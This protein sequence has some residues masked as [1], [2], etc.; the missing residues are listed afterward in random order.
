MT[1]GDVAPARLGL[2]GGA[3][4]ALREAADTVAASDERATGGGPLRAPARASS[5]LH[6]LFSPLPLQAVV[7]VAA[8]VSADALGAAPPPAR[9]ARA[10]LHPMYPVQLVGVGELQPAILDREHRAEDVTDADGPRGRDHAVVRCRPSAHIRGS[11]AVERAPLP[12]EIP[13]PYAGYLSRA[14]AVLDRQDE[15][16]RPGV[17]GAARYV[18]ERHAGIRASAR[19]AGAVTCADANP[20]RDRKPSTPPS[21]L[22]T[23]RSRSTPRRLFQVSARTAASSAA[24]RAIRGEDGDDRRAATRRAAASRSRRRARCHPSSSCTRASR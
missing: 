12:S 18:L 17:D 6:G 14:S 8:I 11:I 22:A 9:T 13:T 7:S 21:R 3:R 10:Q 20:R 5:G 24:L 4:G 16:R 2:G 1:V 19:S 15:E 23:W